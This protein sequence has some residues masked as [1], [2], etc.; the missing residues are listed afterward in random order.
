MATKIRLQRMGKR[1][2]AF[3]RIVLTSEAAKRDGRAIAIL[4]FYDPK[5]RPPLV[6]VDKEK[7]EQW[8]TK[9]AQM[10]QAVRK[11]LTSNSNSQL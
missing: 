4:G 3:F 9:G 1:D 2:E 5:T 11:L 7:L 10:S 8:L 6:K